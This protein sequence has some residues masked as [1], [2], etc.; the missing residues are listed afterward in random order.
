MSWVGA[1][2]RHRGAGGDAARVVRPRCREIWA[3]HI[4]ATLFRNPAGAGI[5]PGECGG[6]CG[7]INPTWTERSRIGWLVRFPLDVTKPVR[8]HPSSRISVMFES[9]VF[10]NTIGPGPMLD[11]GAIAEGLLFYGRVAIVGNSA[12]LKALLAQIPP[13]IALTLLKDRRI[14][15]YYLADQTGVSTVQTTT[16]GNLHDLMRFSSPQHTIEKVGPEVFKAAAG[17]TGQARVGASQFTNHLRPLDHAEFDQKAV[18]QALLD[19]N[20]TES[21]VRA[22]VELAAPGFAASEPLRFRIEPQAQGFCVDTNIDFGSLNQ[23]Y[24]RRVPQEHSS[25]SEAY[26]LA[27]I[28]GAYEATYYAAKLDSE[29]A[30]AP[31][32]QVVQAK[33][34]ESIVQRRTHSASQIASFVDLTT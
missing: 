34:V 5:Y 25:L 32:E 17:S 23:I 1:R 4:G 22:L 19:H 14:E 28:Q 27:L 7:G 12:T 21:S 13:F 18:L 11:A 3:A 10:K 6:E 16:G 9:I 33:A 15:F 26:L 24:H 31:M 8:C 30:V 20:A 29:V 2:C